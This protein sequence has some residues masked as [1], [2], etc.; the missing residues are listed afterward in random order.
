MTKKIKILS[1]AVLVCALLISA[2]SMFAGAATIL[3]GDVD[4]DGRVS[5][6]DARLILR[7]AVN[8]EDLPEEFL[9]AADIDQND[10]I[11]TRDARTTL[12]TAVRLEDQITIET[13]D[14]TQPST[15]P[16]TE[17]TQPTQP[18]TEPTQPTQPTVPVETTEQPVEF[19][20]DDGDAGSVDV[21]QLN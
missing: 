7:H 13:E 10:T 17:P 4:G 19:L 1:A 14:P 11:N 3:L 18:S 5:S 20:P 6:G 15:E 2:M 21:G 8:I 9:I 12:R 16:S